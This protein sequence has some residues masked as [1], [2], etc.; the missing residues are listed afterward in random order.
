[1]PVLVEPARPT[2]AVL[3]SAMPAGVQ[4]FDGLET[5]GEWV[6]SKPEEYCIVVGPGVE[7]GVAMT[8]ADTLRLTRP[9][10]SVILIRES[11]LTSTLAGAMQAGI[12]EVVELEDLHGLRKAV[13]RSRALWGALHDQAATQDSDVGKVITIYSP[14]GGVGK[15]TTAVNLALALA[16]GG[17]HKVCLVDL[18]LSFGD[19][20]ITLQLFP[21]HTIFDA[22]L[23][24]S[25]VDFNLVEPLLTNYGDSIKVLAA[26]PQLDAK[27]QISARL[28][29]G[30]LRTLR[31]N[32]EYVVVDTAPNFDEQVLQ[33]LD[34]TD[35]C[36]LVATLDVPALKNMK[37]AMETLDLLN[38][39]PGH[40]WLLLNRADDL[41]GI[42]PP[43]VESILNMKI[44]TAI[45]TSLDIA[46]A[47]NE[48]RPILLSSQDHPASR[49]FRALA[50]NFEPLPVDEL[51]GTSDGHGGKRRFSRR[52]K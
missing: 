50:R 30:I 19:V 12:R 33:A 4:V 31:E 20:A 44:S 37:I 2:A 40:R 25:H 27:D 21:T 51:A 1:M 7:M 35:E 52:K 38:I 14:K 48:G 24:E 10:T 32:F 39:A 9:A 8:F 22:V 36:I 18:D 34:E 41:V 29:A 5:V 45:P 46:S 28:V 23:A 6:A 47:T 26:P 16:D 42:D 11:V 49:A 3:S 43:K 15:T 13:E 17:D